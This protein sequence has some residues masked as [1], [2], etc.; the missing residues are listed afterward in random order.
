[1]LYAGKN[2][3]KNQRIIGFALETDNEIENAQKKLQSKNADMIVLNSL[4]DKGA[5]FEGNTNKV[6]F[7]HKGNKIKKLELMEKSLLGQEIVNEIL[8]LINPKL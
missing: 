8:K 4:N 2:K 1:M 5:G 6:T 7:I 3:T